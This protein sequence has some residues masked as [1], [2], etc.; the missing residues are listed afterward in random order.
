[1]DAAR[2]LFPAIRHDAAAGFDG[3]RAGAERALALGV[4]GFIVFGGT[5][6]RVRSLIE[7]LRRRAGRPLL[8]GADLERGAG[9][10]FAGATPL[11]PLAALGALGDVEVTR[12]AAELTAREARSLGVDWIY[13]PVADLDIEPRN[14]IVGTRAFG[15]DPERV[16]AHVRAWVD[17]CH[18]GGALACAKHFPG[19]GR[20]IADSHVELP[21][22]QA[23][24]ADLELDLAPFRAAIDA[25]VD[26][27]MS[28]HVAYPALDDGATPA[29]LSRAILT[30][31]LRERLGFDGLVVTDALNMEALGAAEAGEAEVA[32]RAV[33]AGC[34]ALLYPVDVEL[35]A[36]RLREAAGAGGGRPGGDGSAGAAPGA[37]DAG[38]DASAATLRARIAGAVG[39]VQA[40]CERVAR[41]EWRATAAAEGGAEA[42][43]AAGGERPWGRPADRAWAVETATATVRLLRGE[44]ALGVGELD[45]VTIDDDVGG[46]FAPPPRDTLGR[47]LRALGI[48]V[49]EVGD[50]AD[51]ERAAV[52]AVYADIRAWKGR[53]GISAAAR[54]R[55]ER[56]VASRRATTVLL[57]GHP[58][59]GAE[60]AA[61]RVVCAWGG[62]PL[63]Q[64]AAARWIARRAG[65]RPR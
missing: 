9:Q 32:L 61:E 15:A 63:M 44:T 27:L 23:A 5:A 33:A 57:F 29:T 47:T 36:T 53:P 52:I 42:P 62:E 45:L 12:R 30:G 26:S 17:G 13:A 31:L 51:G 11:P 55:I 10:Q 16:S 43:A 19:H 56:V 25:G 64:Q 24:A 7:D 58:R 20:T 49:R 14:P 39:R 50:D 4:G 35:L 3:A 65:S 46:P 41:A 40:A 37:A 34:D 2:L 59:L 6:E 18:A 60:L 21:V 8:F 1:M 48:A 38:G 54:E 28:A 22:V